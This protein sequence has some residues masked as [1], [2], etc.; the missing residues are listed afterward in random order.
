MGSKPRQRRVTAALLRKLGACWY[1]NGR[2][3]GDER[4]AELANGR[5]SMSVTEVLALESVSVAD[6]IWV[7][8]ALLDERSRRLS[9]CDC[10]EHTL[11]LFE[12]THPDD[13]RPR[14]AIAVARRFADGKA[15]MKEL[16]AARDAAWDAAWD[17]ARDAAG[18]AAWYAAWAAA[19]DAVWYAAWATARDAVWA[20]A[21]AADWAAERE[22]QLETLRRYHG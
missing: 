9:A 19:R 6:R 7:G 14:E 20:A 8:I 13:K 2:E 10:A 22:W 1:D 5:R 12:R 21:W 15:T 11:P 18:D 17:A 3:A 4:V 16:D